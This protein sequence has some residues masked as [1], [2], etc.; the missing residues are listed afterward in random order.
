[1]EELEYFCPKCNTHRELKNV[2]SKCPECGG[3]CL[4]VVTSPKAI[5]SL[6][7]FLETECVVNPGV[8]IHPPQV[9]AHRFAIFMGLDFGPSE[10]IA[11]ANSRVDTH[12]VRKMLRQGCDINTAVAILL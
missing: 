10:A 4:A 6:D 7:D 2:K 12:Q 5:E 9:Y 3:K 1:M 11:L 8:R